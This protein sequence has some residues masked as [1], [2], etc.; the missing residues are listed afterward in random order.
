MLVFLLTSALFL[1]PDSGVVRVGGAIPKPL[2][3]SYQDPV[4]KLEGLTPVGIVI[5]DLTV[6]EQGQ[7]TEVTF[8]RGGGFAKNIDVEAIKRWRYQ[9]C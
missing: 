1:T 9:P 6:D 4:R 7:P 3:T 8:V 2:R 5:L